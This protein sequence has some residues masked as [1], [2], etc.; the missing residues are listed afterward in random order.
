MRRIGL[1]CLVLLVH[2]A[3][4]N[5]LQ[6]RA[7]YKSPETLSDQTDVLLDSLL[8]ESEKAMFGDF[9][10]AKELASQVIE[11]SER[12]GKPRFLGFGYF[13][14]A[15]NE[16]AYGNWEL[17]AESFNK[18]LNTLRSTDDSLA[19]ATT[20]DRMG[21][22][23]RN[24][25]DLTK[26]LE[27]QLEALYLREQFD[28]P[29]FELGNSYAS[30]GGVYYQLSDYEKAREYYERGFELRQQA[31]DSMGI[32]LSMKGLGR[33]NRTLEQYEEAKNYLE[34]SLEIFKQKGSFTHVLDTEKELGLLYR[35]MEDFEASE[36]AFKRGLS[37]SSELQSG[38][39]AALILL[40]LGKLYTE[41]N[42]NEQAEKYLVE[43]RAKLTSG[44]NLNRLQEV[45]KLLSDIYVAENKYDLALSHLNASDALKD[46]IREREAKNDISRLTSQFELRQKEAEL[47]NLRTAQTFQIRQRNSLIIGLILAGSLLTAL[48]V[49]FIQRI[50]AYRHLFEEKS[51]TEVLL[52]EKEE[53]Y[54][55][56][57]SAHDQLVQSEKMASLGQLTAGIAHEINNPVNY[58]SSSA[59]ALE[60]NFGELSEKFNEMTTS[61]PA[62]GNTQEISFIAKETD[63]L[64]NGIKNGTRRISEI[65]NNL[66][67]FSRQSDG[68]FDRA[69]INE[70]LDSS[71]T[72]L[73]SKLNGMINVHK[74][75]AKL[76][77]VE[78]QYLRISQVFLNL[79]NNAIDAMPKGGD[80]Y[81]KT[82]AEEENVI[83]HIQD[84]GSGIS[85][86]NKS[87]LM[88]PF[89][90]TKE[91]GKGT[92]LGLSISYG[93]IQSHNG[94]ITVRSDEGVG[95][96]FEVTL[97]INASSQRAK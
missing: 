29:E 90:T 17:S 30:V 67:V 28:A 6:S 24:M 25:G 23:Y 48:V 31:Q 54:A 86:E 73:G 82:E 85:E 42:N 12:S 3:E 21:Y 14:M 16:M 35:S 57:K 8:F 60:M 13:F 71:L 1:I 7:F 37:A 74:D 59:H 96:T 97:P 49:V 69:N 43:S 4:L 52:K 56:L 88:E 46:T 15:M 83:I 94:K 20:L 66:K 84:T 63:Q 36:K 55:N 44:H 81:I 53:L 22:A 39:R 70:C 32:A 40:E 11:I 68:E 26:C 33:L 61:L 87:K 50:K 47:E 95:S 89:F 19:V 78:C 10:A 41:W 77:L 9:V 72:I 64:I 2:V 27:V 51:K 58:I 75:Y 79:I 80:I 93:I 38:G 62:K 92:G 34:K 45:E 76:P 65:V 18:S 5:A 91:I